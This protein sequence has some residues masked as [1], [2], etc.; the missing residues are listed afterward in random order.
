VATVALSDP[1]Q[2]DEARRR[3]LERCECRATSA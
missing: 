2:I 3:H 1:H